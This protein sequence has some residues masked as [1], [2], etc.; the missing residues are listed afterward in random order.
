MFNRKRIAN[1]LKRRVAWALNGFP[2]ELPLLE[3]IWPCGKQAN[4]IEIPK[5]YLLRQF[6]GKDKEHHESLM[7]ITGMGYCSLHYWQ[8]HILPSGFFVVEHK[9]TGKIVASCFASHHP[10][11]RHAAGGN[12][13]WLAVDPQHQGLGLGR[14]VSVQVTRRL[15]DGYYRNIYLET[16]DHRLGA[17]KVYLSIGW[18]PLIYDQTSCDRWEIVCRSLNWSFELKKWDALRSELTGQIAIKRG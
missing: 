2:V 12:L 15:I 14:L 4:H 10:T 11:K 3:M 17:I 1:G 8:K 9:Q 7:E 13:G 18:V 6:E 5:G 16:H